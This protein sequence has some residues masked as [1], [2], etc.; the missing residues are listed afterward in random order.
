M[1]RLLLCSVLSRVGLVAAALRLQSRKRSARLTVLTYHRAGPP[2]PL[3][4]V[5]GA[6]V[7]AT[8]EAADLC[9]PYRPLLPPRPNPRDRA[10]AVLRAIHIA[11][12]W[13][14]LDLPRFLDHLGERA[15]APDNDPSERALVDRHV[16]TWDHVRALRR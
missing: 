9:S 15:G 16:M 8:R 2:R 12:E 14:G 6:V 4:L 10:A 5:D 7:S 3:E 13:F 1:K 11:K